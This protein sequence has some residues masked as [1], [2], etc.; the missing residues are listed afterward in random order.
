MKK[1]VG[2]LFGAFLFSAIPVFALETGALIEGSVRAW[3]NDWGKVEKAK[4]AELETKETFTLNAKQSLNESGSRY[5]AVEGNV[6]YKYTNDALGNGDDKIF[7]DV[8]LF[9]YTAAYDYNGAKNV[10]NL[11]RFF[12][13]DF[14]GLIFAQQNDGVMFQYFANTVQASVYGGWTGLLNAQTTTILP[15]RSS[16]FAFDHDA[17]YDFQSSYF[18]GSISLSLPYVFFNQTASA[19]CITLFG[20]NGINGDNSETWR[21]YGTF[22]L[23]GSLASNL[24]Y[25]A[26]TTFATEA[27]QDMM[28][29]SA[30][31]VDFYPNYKN[32]D[33]GI[34]FVYATPT[35]DGKSAFKGITS[36]T[37]TFAYDEPQYSAMMKMG[38]S[39]SIK[40]VDTLL[41]RVGG[42][43]VFAY[44][45]E[46]KRA[47]PS[48]DLGYHGFQ[49][50]ANAVYQI[51]T[52][53]K[54]TLFFSDFIGNKDG[55]NKILG[56]VSLTVAL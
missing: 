39:A 55:Y 25:T 10:I 35:K 9:K 46:E 26:H 17:A 31:Y 20:T 5:L 2:F 1:S 15:A 27:E 45:D 50:Y 22:A 6:Q 3:S 36:Q 53:M 19:E 40:P 52:D 49:I 37:A 48:G 18:V 23:N 16:D 42:D 28:N 51:F 7:A 56:A 43:V 34:N 30:V 33:L 12:V 11:G 8:T 29:L 44:L 21:V 14:T 13:S 4:D 32:M 47:T 41:T 38:A 24:F 54:A